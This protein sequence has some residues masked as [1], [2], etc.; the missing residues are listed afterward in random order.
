MVQGQVGIKQELN[1][2][3]KSNV[4]VIRESDYVPISKKVQILAPI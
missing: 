3:E 4:Q 2:V 1:A